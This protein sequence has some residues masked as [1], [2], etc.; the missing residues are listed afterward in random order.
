MAAGRESWR[1]LVRVSMEHDVKR[2]ID[3]LICKRFLSQLNDSKTVRDRPYVS[4]GSYFEAKGELSDK[5]I[6]SPHVLSNILRG[7]RGSLKSPPFKFQPTSWRLT[8]IS[9]EHILGC[10][11]WLWSDAVNNRAS[12]RH[13][14]KWVDADWTQ[15]LGSSSGTITIVVM[16]LCLISVW[17]NTVVVF[18]VL[19][20]K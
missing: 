18:E 4:M 7:R 3:W 2:L 17:Q 8:K 14:P 9:F 13:S 19:Y 16:T 11:G 10:I 5:P 12:F 20:R 1:W 15:Y 6:S